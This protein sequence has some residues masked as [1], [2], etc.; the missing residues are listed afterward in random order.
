MS[1]VKGTWLAVTCVKQKN[2]RKIQ[3]GFIF[4]LSQND[5]HPQVSWTK[6]DAFGVELKL[7]NGFFYV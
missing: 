2:S 3:I 1:K 4:F 5:F 7:P 6:T